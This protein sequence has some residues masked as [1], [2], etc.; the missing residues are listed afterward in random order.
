MSDGESSGKGH[1]GRGRRNDR[2]LTDVIITQMKD[3]NE[4]STIHSR[5]VY[6]RDSVSFLLDSIEKERYNESFSD[7]DLQKALAVA[8]KIALCN[9]I[10]NRWKGEDVVNFETGECFK[11]EGKFYRC[12]NRLCFDCLANFQRRNRKKIRN[13]IKDH[14]Q[15]VGY[16]YR[17]ITFTV[18]N[19]NST[20]QESRELINR[21]WQ[22]FR[23]RKYFLKTFRAGVKCE[24]FTFTKTG[25]HYHI[26]MIAD[27]KYIMYAK[28]RAEWT[29]CYL[30]AA[31]EIGITD[32]IATSDGLLQV[33]AKNLY[34]SERGIFEVT[35]YITKSSSWRQISSEDLIEYAT[36]KR[37]PRMTEFFGEWRS[38][39]ALPLPDDDPEDDKFPESAYIETIVHK[40]NISDG[41]FPTMDVMLENIRQKAIETSAFRIKQ[42]RWKQPNAILS[43]K[44][45]DNY[46]NS[47]RERCLVLARP[48]YNAAAIESMARLGMNVSRFGS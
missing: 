33:N 17:F 46:A 38:S 26:H 28:L 24:E 40:E 13:L 43:Y 45:S 42:I 4:K 15:L 18:V 30:K 27:T 23:K 37:H 14:K 36:L 8:Y 39:A 22:L 2:P 48:R 44:K 9:D 21:T 11:A 35:K 29:E 12:N 47:I 19:H 5:A 34:D 16:N 25:F 31:A 20:L 3:S 32:G 10:S 6:S 41:T 7:F 1:L